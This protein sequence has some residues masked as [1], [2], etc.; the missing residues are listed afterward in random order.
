MAPF[1]QDLEPPQFPGR[2]RTVIVPDALVPRAICE[3]VGRTEKEV[4]QQMGIR[5]VQAGKPR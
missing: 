3:S 5:M 4:K 1:S 2:F